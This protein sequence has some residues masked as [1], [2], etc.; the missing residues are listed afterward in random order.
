M[1]KAAARA[2]R[3]WARG[4]LIKRSLFN[5]VDYITTSSPEQQKNILMKKEI[6]TCG[7][8]FWW[9]MNPP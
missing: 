1:V 9:T 6:V 3:Q 2:T 4:P 8:Y 5:C 7:R